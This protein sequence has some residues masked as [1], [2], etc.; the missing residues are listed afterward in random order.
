MGTK[1]MVVDKNDEYVIYVEKNGWEFTD[2]EI[3]S[4]S[5]ER[6]EQYIK[7]K[8]NPD[9]YFREDYN[10]SEEDF[11]KILN[12]IFNKKKMKLYCKKDLDKDLNISYCIKLVK[13]Y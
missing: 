13:L 10:I 2:L 7:K 5:P 8:I 11:Y 3:I 6:V 1:K 12:N 4:K 9:L